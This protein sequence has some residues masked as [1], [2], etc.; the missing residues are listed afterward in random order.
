MHIDH[1]VTLILRVDEQLGPDKAVEFLLG[2]QGRSI[3]HDSVV[4]LFLRLLWLG[5]HHWIGQDAYV[6]ADLDADLAVGV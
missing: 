1:L 4:G 5:L 6:C 2:K 3:D